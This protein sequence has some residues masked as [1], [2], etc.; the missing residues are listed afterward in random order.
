LAFLLKYDSKDFSK[1]KKTDLTKK[2]QQPYIYI[3]SCTLSEWKKW[4]TIP[5]RN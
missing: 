4:N 5:F 3:V 1:E 2:N